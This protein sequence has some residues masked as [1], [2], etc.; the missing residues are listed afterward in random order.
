MRR[1]YNIDIRHLGTLN[2]R[3]STHKNENCSRHFIVKIITADSQNNEFLWHIAG[4]K[5]KCLKEE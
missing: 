4:E 3:G 2:Q 5:I 1:V